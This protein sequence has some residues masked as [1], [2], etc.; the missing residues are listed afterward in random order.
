MSILEQIMESL[1]KLLVP[2]IMRSPVSSSPAIERL[3][4]FL[5]RELAQIA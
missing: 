4:D 5:R 3:N 2:G 1:D